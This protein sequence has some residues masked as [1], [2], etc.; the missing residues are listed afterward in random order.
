MKNKSNNKEKNLIEYTGRFIPVENEDNMTKK[1]LFFLMMVHY[2][3]NKMKIPA[4]NTLLFMIVVKLSTDIT[5]ILL[6]Y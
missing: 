4:K 1:K 2:I 6:I 5:R 3:R